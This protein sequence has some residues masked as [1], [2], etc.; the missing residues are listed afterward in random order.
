MLQNFG[1]ENFLNN[2]VGEQEI[3]FEDGKIKLKDLSG[4]ILGALHSPLRVLTDLSA[5]LENYDMQS[6][7]DDIKSLLQTGLLEPNSKKDVDDFKS[8]FHLLIER[9]LYLKLVFTP[10]SGEADGAAD[11]LGTLRRLVRQTT[12]ALHVKKISADVYQLTEQEEYANPV[13]KFCERL[14]INTYFEIVVMVAIIMGSFLLA[15]EGPPTA[16]GEPEPIEW[17]GDPRQV[18]A[19]HVTG[20]WDEGSWSCVDASLQSR[21]ANSRDGSLCRRLASAGLGPTTSCRP[22]TSRST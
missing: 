6:E 22:L 15:F 18:R 5:A 12:A 7:Q 21:F 13:R 10:K 19:R 2:D 1:D 9:N 8:I 11:T 16:A 4:R 20:T 17:S 14:A 3:D